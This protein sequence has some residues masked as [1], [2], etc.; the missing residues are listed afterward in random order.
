MNVTLLVDIAGRVSMDATNAD[1]VTVA[2]VCLPSGALK[3][4]RKQIP[5]SLPKWRDSSDPN[6]EH[7]V[8]L[9]QK[10]AFAVC[11]ISLR[12]EDAWAQFWE[13]GNEAHQR[14]S[15]RAKSPIAIMK[16]ATMVK[17]ALFGQCTTV[18]LAHAIKNNKFPRVGPSNRLL[19]IRETHIYDKEIEGD[20]NVAAFVD[21]WK[22]RNQHQPL[23]N[24]LGVKLEAVDVY[25]TTEQDEP[26]LLL[27]DYV[28]GIAH[29]AHSQADTLS[30]S[31]V[32]RECAAQARNYL[33]ASK[34]Y[35]EV[36]KAFDIRYYDI[37]PDFTQNA[38]DAP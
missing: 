11:A 19:H 21:V 8:K 30:A 35:V 27:P 12:K 10:E 9:L 22:I 31:H 1:R 14:I 15:M 32:S 37:Y 23:V 6:V 3:S 16:P 34:G 24:R 17:F 2:C 29:A 18:A 28:A 25:L 7:V 33:R 4:I 20:E 38:E 36:V 26:L 13:E 5:S